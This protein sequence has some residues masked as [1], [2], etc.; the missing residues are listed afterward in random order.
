[1]AS[2]GERIVHKMAVRNIVL[3]CNLQCHANL[4]RAYERSAQQDDLLCWWNRAFGSLNLKKGSESSL[5]Q[6]FKTGRIIV[7]GGRSMEEADAL[8]QMYLNVL[9]HLA[10]RTE[11]S[12]YRVQNVVATYSLGKIVSLNRLKRVFYEPE[13]FP[14][15][16][17]V[18][19]NPKATVNIFATGSCTILGFKDVNSLPSIIDQINGII[20]ESR[21]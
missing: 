15:A 2:G 3:T 7:I 21:L 12:G 9:R 18:C 1:M 4:E 14:A 17:F 13:L 10:I 8:F 11:N 5:C 20:A 19:I 6:V 16:T